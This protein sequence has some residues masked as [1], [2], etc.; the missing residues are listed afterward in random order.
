MSIENGLNFPAGSHFHPH[1]YFFIS[2]PLLFGSI[3]RRY[4]NVKGNE[5]KVIL[6]YIALQL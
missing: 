2:L 3:A 4:T 5:N 1:E 6:L